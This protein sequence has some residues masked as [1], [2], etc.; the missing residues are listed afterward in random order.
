MKFERIPAEFL[1]SIYSASPDVPDA[2]WHPNFLVRKLFYQR[3]EAITNLFP[4]NTA[5][6]VVCD[7]GGGGGVFLLTLSQYFQ[8][9]V[10]MDFEVSEAKQIVGRYGLQNVEIVEGD[11]LSNSLPPNSFD[12]LI[13][14][15]VL[16]HFVSLADPL[17]EI[18]RLLRPGGLLFV[19]APT[20]TMFYRLGRFFAGYEK[21]KDHYHTAREIK[22]A[23]EKSSFRII[24][25]RSLPC[26]IPF[27]RLFLILKAQKIS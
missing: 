10:L 22:E 14:A 23:I 11:V 4:S 17:R 2:Y 16:E 24:K 19:S 3:L 20:E 5:H 25:E 9:V 15:D 21:P 7:F 12:V 26:S 13:A 18:S 8:K 27:F 6:H 1:K